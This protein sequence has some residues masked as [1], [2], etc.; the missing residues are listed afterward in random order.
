MKCDLG[1]QHCCLMV[2]FS[3]PCLRHSVF[4]SAVRENQVCLVKNCRYSDNQKL[5]LSSSPSL[6]HTHNTHKTHVNNYRVIS[7][8]VSKY[9]SD[10]CVAGNC[11]VSLQSQ[12]LEKYICLLVIVL[13]THVHSLLAVPAPR[14]VA[15]RLLREDKH[16][17]DKLWN[18]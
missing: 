17:P 3:A 9:G 1:K 10:V 15:R 14:C 11:G 16:Y 13:T 18:I 7:V 2:Q 6:P 8:P 5:Y 4:S 12:A